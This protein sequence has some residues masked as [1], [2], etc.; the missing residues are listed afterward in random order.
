MKKQIIDSQSDHTKLD[1]HIKKTLNGMFPLPE[2][3][4]NARNEAYAKI[5]AMAADTDKKEEM[6]EEIVKQ[7]EKST[8]GSKKARKI[9]FP[10]FAGIAA[11]VAVF[12]CI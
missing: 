2:Q 10:G 3:V 8:K 9:F 5:R 11:V 7:Q 1:E 12:F 6:D 4:E